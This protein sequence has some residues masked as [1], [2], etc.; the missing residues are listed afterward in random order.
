[1]A[2]NIDPDLPKVGIPPLNKVAYERNF[3]AAK[4]EIEG[5]DTRV[6][7]LEGGGPGGGVTSFET[8]TGAVTG[9]SGDYAI[10]EITG[11]GALASLNTVSA[12]EIDANAVGP[13][14]LAATTV[15]PAAY[16]SAD[17]TVDA[18]G[19]VTA[20]ANGSGGSGIPATIVDAKGD[21]IAATAADTVA[22]LGVGTNGQI[23]TADS[24]E[25]TGVKW[26]TSAAGASDQVTIVVH[27]TGDMRATIQTALDAAETAFAIDG[28]PRIVRLQNGEIYLIDS[29]VTHNYRAVGRAGVLVGS[30]VW[31]DLNGSTLKAGDS[32]NM[33]TCATKNPLA[34]TPEEQIR[35]Y[36]G[37][38]D[39]NVANQSNAAA[40][41]FEEFGSLL[42]QNVEQS[43]FHNL[44]FFNSAFYAGEFLDCFNGTVMEH[45]RMF[46]GDADGFRFGVG[47]DT[48]DACVDCN[49]NNIYTEDTPNGVMDYTPVGRSD[50]QGNGVVLHI[51]RCQ[52]DK[53]KT[54]N[55]GGGI[56]FDIG[57]RNQVGL[58]YFDGT[59]PSGQTDRATSNS[60]V[61]IQGLTTALEVN[62]S[63]FAS[64]ISIDCFAE[65]LRLTECKGISI[66]S[67]FGRNNV[68]GAGGR[69][70][71]RVEAG[72][73]YIGHIHIFE[74]NGDRGIL[75]DGTSPFAPRLSV[76][77]IIVE[78]CTDTSNGAIDVIESN[79]VG[80][81]LLINQLRIRG[82]A[83]GFDAVDFN[84][85]GTAHIGILAIDT[86]DIEGDVVEGTTITVGK[87]LNSFD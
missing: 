74:S 48:E 79:A 50:P 9:Q 6:T 37:V 52:V 77:D 78:D 7:A 60:G 76:G 20:A 53:I 12:T 44:D 17:I 22:R 35:V 11:A 46:G 47:D 61:K 23:L 24:A 64:I 1:M 36:G 84:A 34:G 56:K 55:A 66:G 2:S 65:G 85:A 27:A 71:I 73:N 57:E 62:N 8:R 82:C 59:V 86:A 54:V 75:L 31:F 87:F 68:R 15:T 19:R 51:T 29:F 28:V 5:L 38:F 13:T 18:Q 67:Y 25:A 33:W 16:T 21:L 42:V 83:A 69:D 45:L 72:P 32:T 81:T 3:G 70:E 39:G 43:K 80:T 4:T 14:Q 49:I 10:G 26:A 63:T 40:A 30:G 41:A 58:V